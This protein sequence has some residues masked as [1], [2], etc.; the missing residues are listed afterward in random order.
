MLSGKQ[1]WY[2]KPE[3]RITKLSPE[4]SETRPPLT[5][6]QEEFA[7]D[8][9]EIYGLEDISNRYVERKD[10][11]GNVIQSGTVRETLVHC[12]E[13][14]DLEPEAA[15]LIFKTALGDKTTSGDA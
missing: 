2:T 10:E 12:E 9:V 3:I 15:R 14:H 11:A 1:T 8:M 5:K 6:A 7:D 4:K 13:F